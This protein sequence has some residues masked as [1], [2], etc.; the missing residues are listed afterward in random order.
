MAPTVAARAA[1]D[2]PANPPVRIS[3]AL[4]WLVDL[5]ATVL[6]FPVPYAT[7]LNPITTYFYEA[8]GVPGVVLA[9]SAYAA[10]VVLIGH[11][12]SKPYDTLFATGAV[13]VYAVCAIN[14]VVLLFSGDAPFELF[15]V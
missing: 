3:F 8:I 11:Y 1:L 14:N 6:L 2:R 9:G 13:L 12:L 7:E 4:F 15:V 10:V 5:I